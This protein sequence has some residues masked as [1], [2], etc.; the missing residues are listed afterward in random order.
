[1]SS[2]PELIKQ[3]RFASPAHEAMLNV[4]VTYPW[5]MGE[6]ASTMECHEVTPAQYNVLRILRGAGDKGLSALSM[7]LC[8]AAASARGDGRFAEPISSAGATPLVFCASAPV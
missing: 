5:L 6:L 4:M 7:T 3:D 1:M 2:L 8:P